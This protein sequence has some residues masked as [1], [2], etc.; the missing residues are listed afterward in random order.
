M[1]K[2]K[3]K[4]IY[5][6]L[7][8]SGKTSIILSIKQKFSLMNGKP[9]V[10]LNRSTLAETK[11][12]GLEF[13]TWDLGGQAR[14]RDGY[15]KQRYRVFSNVETMFYIVDIQDPERFDES[16][17]YFNNILETYEALHETPRI[18]ICFHKSDPDI[19]DSKELIDESI[20]FS[21]LIGEKKGDHEILFFKTTIHDISTI[22]KAFS[23]SVIKGSPKAI[24]IGDFLKEYAKLTFSS[25][26]LLLDD[27]SLIIGNHSSNKKYI[28][29]CE[30]VAPRFITAM[31][32]MDNYGIT[33]ENVIV[34]I[35]FK[36]NSSE[37]NNTEENDSA[38][39]FVKSFTAIEGEK[40]NLVTLSRNKTTFKLSEKY[41]PELANRLKN[42]INACAG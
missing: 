21:K 4:I 7:D 9:T 18:T 39:V 40:F 25:A 16:L 23:E 27:N 15:F 19:R 37:P 12:L 14:F 24:M 41:L 10:G 38:M 3:K 5:A 6:G 30:A 31:E 29:I 36:K 17:E 20:K 1:A 34:N 22:I 32:R 13:V 33:P 28:E 11:C 35:K 42:L 26:V 8:N 2:Q